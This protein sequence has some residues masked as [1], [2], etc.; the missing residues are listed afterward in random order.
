[1]QVVVDAGPARVVVL[2]ATGRGRGSSATTA[3]AAAAG[4]G[5]DAGP[6][7]TEGLGRGLRCRVEGQAG[8][9]PRFWSRS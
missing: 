4:A 6:V 1:L 2:A 7:R 9:D 5:T 3:A 8:S